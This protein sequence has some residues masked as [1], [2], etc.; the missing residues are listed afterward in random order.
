MDNHRRNPLALQ[1]GGYQTHGLVAH[2]SDGDEE[3]DI[4]PVLD[5]QTGGR[6]RRIDDEM[7]G[8]RDRSHTGKVAV[9]DRA[10]RPAAA[11][12]QIRSIEKARLGSCCIP[13]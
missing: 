8:R 4:H 12:S 5:Q 13:V 6:R 11:S 2:G 9:V 1:F 10:I 3:R 7:A